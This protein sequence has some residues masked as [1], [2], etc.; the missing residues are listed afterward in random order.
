MAEK[1]TLAFLYLLPS[2][3]TTDRF[4]GGRP[5]LASPKMQLR[6]GK[7]GADWEEVI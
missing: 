7:E 2:T 4:V 6:G 3:F 1:W 5:L